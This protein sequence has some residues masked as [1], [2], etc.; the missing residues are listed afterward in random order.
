MSERLNPSSGR[1]GQRRRGLRGSAPQRRELPSA[2]GS[3]DSLSRLVVCRCG[4]RSA[5]R[6]LEGH[7]TGLLRYCSWLGTGDRGLRLTGRGNPSLH[8]VN[9]LHKP[10][11][12]GDLWVAERLRVVAGTGHC[13]L[14]YLGVV[15]LRVVLTKPHRLFTTARS[16][17]LLN[18]GLQRGCR[19]ALGLFSD[20]GL[21]DL[22][23]AARAG[24][25]RLLQL[26]RL[27]RSLLREVRIELRGSAIAL[28]LRGIPGLLGELLWH[29]LW[30]LRRRGHEAHLD[31]EWVDLLR[32]DVRLDRVHPADQLLHLVALKR[33]DWLRG[34][35]PGLDRRLRLCL[36][37]RLAG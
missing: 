22:G 24:S 6:R 29:T 34:S 9:Q 5:T 7:C 3:E 23:V 11:L 14:R 10:R 35:L 36:R 16:F 12:A 25:S 26:A 30:R 1:Y 37:L 18:V 2:T 4:R 8:E 33:R 20:V 31:C 28:R 15:Q 21:N 17:L 32:R 27:R 13:F 19:L